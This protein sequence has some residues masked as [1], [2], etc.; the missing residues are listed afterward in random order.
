MEELKQ[1]IVEHW[2]TIVEY[3]MLLVSY[4]LVFLYKSIVNKTKTTLTLLFKTNTK[5][6]QEELT[7]SKAN[8]DTAVSKISN[9]EVQLEKQQRIINALIGDSDESICTDPEDKE[10]AD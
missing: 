3:A 6:M 4:F 2:S 10:N 7:Q 1:I 9:L 8:Y 5:Q